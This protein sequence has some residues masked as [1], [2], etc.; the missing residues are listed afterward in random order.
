MEDSNELIKLF[1]L[2]VTLRGDSK[3][4]QKHYVCTPMLK[5]AVTMTRLSGIS[6]LNAFLIS[7]FKSELEEEDDDGGK[8]LAVRE[9]LIK[10][11]EIG[12]NDRTQIPYVIM[13]IKYYISM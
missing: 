7:M 6:K 13:V 2:L 3:G 11:L 12:V 8:K 4:K 9:F 1:N 5:L 10:A